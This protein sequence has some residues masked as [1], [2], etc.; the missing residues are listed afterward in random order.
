MYLPPGPSELPKFGLRTWTAFVSFIGLCLVWASVV[1]SR[2]IP[3]LENTSASETADLRDRLKLQLALAVAG[4]VAGLASHLMA[5][6]RDRRAS[7]LLCS[8]AAAL[9]A[10]AGLVMASL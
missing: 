6:R 4:L 3:K 5:W 1:L 10:G 9:L 7:I 2:F 8:A